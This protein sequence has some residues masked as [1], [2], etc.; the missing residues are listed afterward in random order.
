MGVRRQSAEAVP[1]PLQERVMSRQIMFIHGMFLNAK[2]WELW[3]DYF[4]KRGYECHAPSWPLHA[5]DPAE[6]RRNLPTGLGE[7]HLETVV[8][9]AREHVRALDRPILIGHSLGGLIVQRLIGEGLGAMGVA[10][11]SVAPNMMLSLDWGLLKNSVAIGNPLKG[12]EP[13]LMDADGFNTNFGN[14]MPRAAADAAFFEYAMSESRNVLRDAIGDAGRVDVEAPHA[15]LLFIGAD[16]DGIIP[17][18]LVR[19]NAQAY[20]DTASRSE[21]R[22]FRNRSH[23]IC[24]QTGWE[25]V[26]GFVANWL[27]GQR[28]LHGA[29]DG[30]PAP[31][32]GERQ[33]SRYA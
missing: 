13:Y 17:A 8:D 31:M 29:A 19:K 28:H 4:E 24:G 23:F 30:R 9:A 5:G 12:D 16:K 22:E 3:A 27:S 18:S 7:L 26:A 21:Y 2:S 33:G 1:T 14:T 11:C 20:T 10:I 6:L 15:P 32:P 25:E